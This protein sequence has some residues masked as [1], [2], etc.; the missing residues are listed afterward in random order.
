MPAEA[1]IEFLRQTV[2]AELA[3]FTAARLRN[4][5][6]A[7]LFRLSAGFLSAMT[8]VLLG[9]QISDWQTIT[10][11]VALVLSALVSFLSLWEGIFNH[12][13]LWIRYTQTVGELR[14]LLTSVNYLTCDGTEGVKP[15][16]VDKLFKRYERIMVET[17]DWWLGLRNETKA[18]EGP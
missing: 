6:K 7:W 11:N 5:R 9:V 1:K 3:S 17:N 14:A 4:K 13:S 15:E 18:R 16:E 8:T 12:R 10:R 2:N